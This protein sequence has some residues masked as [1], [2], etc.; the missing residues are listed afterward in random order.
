M[1]TV[2][3]DQCASAGSFCSQEWLCDWQTIAAKRA[4]CRALSG[5]R[6]KLHISAS[7]ISDHRMIRQT[8][9]S[10]HARILSAR[11]EF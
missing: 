7:S 6:G 2:K 9:D 5:I 4:L 8:P 3:I 10:D 1:D 11:A